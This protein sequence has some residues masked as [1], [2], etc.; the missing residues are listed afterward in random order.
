MSAILP[1]PEGT[2]VAVKVQA[3][4]RHNEV[5][6]ENG[7]RLKIR[8]T[9]APEKGKANQA[10]LELLADTLGVR[11]SQLELVSGRTSTQKRILIRNLPPEEVTRRLAEK[12]Q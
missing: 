8:V 5:Q 6:W 9:Q 1:H 12:A 2:L 11:E 4:A 3:G 7:G 10:V